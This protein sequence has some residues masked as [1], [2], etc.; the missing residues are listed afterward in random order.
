MQEDLTS[1]GGAFFKTDGHIKYEKSPCCVPAERKLFVVYTCITGGYD[2]LRPVSHPDPRLDYVCFT[3]NPA[4]S[5]AG[6]TIRPMPED[7][8]G[9]S[10]V[11]Q[12]RLVKIRPDKYLP[13]YDT[14][15]WLD[16]NL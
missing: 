1:G 2:I 13:E 15:L 3:D 14:S 12:Q 5:A 16:A 7:L 8:A 4:T 6:W 9:F 11:K 10:K